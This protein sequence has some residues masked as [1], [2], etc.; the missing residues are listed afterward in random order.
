MSPGRLPPWQGRRKEKGR[1]SQPG[2]AARGRGAHHQRSGDAGDA[3]PAEPHPRRVLCLRVLP[4]T[5]G[6]VCAKH[7]VPPEGEVTG[8]CSSP[9]FSRPRALPGTDCSRHDLKGLC[10]SWPLLLQKHSSK[11]F[12]SSH[13]VRNSQPS[14]NSLIFLQ[15][16][17]IK[18][19]FQLDPK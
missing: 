6:L 13:C 19:S 15:T 14:I 11:A 5:W 8:V 9:R 16:S 3:L 4:E 12:C 2:S 17:I 7:E 18:V 1:C 10:C